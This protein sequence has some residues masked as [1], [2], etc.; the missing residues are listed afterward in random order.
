MHEVRDLKVVTSQIILFSIFLFE[1]NLCSRSGFMPYGTMHQSLLACRYLKVDA[2]PFTVELGIGYFRKYLV[3]SRTYFLSAEVLND[4]PCEC[5]F[6]VLH[7]LLH[8]HV[9]FITIHI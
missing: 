2:C 4:R 5:F 1:A 3:P 9:E 7:R 8:V 6:T